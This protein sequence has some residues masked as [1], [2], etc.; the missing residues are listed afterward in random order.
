M[1]NSI[2]DTTPL[3]L[4]TLILQK[5]ISQGDLDGIELFSEQI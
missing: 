1:V 3:Q 2:E 4:D 5:K